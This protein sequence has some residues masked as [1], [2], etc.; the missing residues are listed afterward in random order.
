M[1]RVKSILSLIL[2]ALLLAPALVS[3]GNDSSAAVTTASTTA[4]GETT[5]A[6]QDDIYS[7]LASSDFSGYEFR[8]LNNES[9]FALTLMTADEQNG[10]VINDTVYSR[11][12]MI[13]DKLNIKI[14]ETTKK[15]DEVISTIRTAI[16]SGEDAY[17][18]FF[19]E[20]YVVTPLALEGYLNNVYDIESIDF[21]KPWWNKEMID[22]LG[23]GDKLYIL[24]GDLHLMLSESTWVM[25]FNKNIQ[26]NSGLASPYELV[27]NGAWTLD[28]FAEYSSAAASDLDGDGIMTANTDRF[29]ATLY[30]NA[31]PFITSGG[32]TPVTKDSSNLPVYNG[33]SERFYSLYESLV[34]N[35][36]T[37]KNICIAGITPGLADEGT[38]WHNIFKNGQA[39]F[40][41][42]VLGSLKKQRAMEDEFGI[43]PFPK[44]EESQDGY[45]NLIA[46]YAAVL[47]I[48][49]TN[50]DTERTGTILEYLCA[51]SYRDLRPAYY[52][53]LL[54]GK[55]VRDDES[56]EM[57]N[58][59]FADSVFDLAAVYNWGSLTNTINEKA[60]AGKSDIA[61]AME[62]LNNKVNSDIEK[63]VSY[64]TEG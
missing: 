16:Q 32:E 41:C 55:Y 50:T 4:A 34:S 21:E 52:D 13:E 53:V 1:N 2:C 11:N 25:A 23:I 6:A 58:L 44:Y 24:A 59:I 28:K 54:E 48:P 17:D 27:K 33:M 47:G 38:D 12:S 22:S 3:C 39:L 8:I 14:T 62:K 26:N 36:Y 51:Y 46:N 61:S 64:Y 43:I 45:K 7:S 60:K 5:A 49:V 10:E 63:T 15:Y 30:V 18:V 35:V 37:N 57:L 9:D 42:E 19:D 40:Y 20:S 56:A 29:G 31:T